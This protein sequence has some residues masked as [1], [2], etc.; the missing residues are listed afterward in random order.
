MSG[1]ANVHASWPQSMDAA[2]QGRAAPLFGG[3]LHAVTQG[4]GW[5]AWA[6]SDAPW[7]K[8]HPLNRSLGCTPGL[9][10]YTRW[11]WRLAQRNR[12]PQLDQEMCL[13][14]S[15]YISNQIREHG[16]WSDCDRLVHLW[17]AIQPANLSQ[18]QED[19]PDRRRGQPSRSAMRDSPSDGGILL[20]AGA[21]IGACTVELLLRTDARILAFEPSRSTCST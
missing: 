13:A 19:E 21:N 9:L 6:P 8:E 14:P 2:R 12:E 10:R 17:R 16:Q 18:P 11:Q 1:F 5:R 7:P 15:D 20:E 4:H 3:A